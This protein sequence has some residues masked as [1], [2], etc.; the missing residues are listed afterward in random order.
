MVKDLK[1]HF[2]PHFVRYPQESL[3]GHQYLRQD[4]SNSITTAQSIKPKLRSAKNV[5]KNGYLRHHKPVLDHK[6]YRMRK[7][8]RNIQQI[9]ERLIVIKSPRAEPLLAAALPARRRKPYNYALA[10]FCSL[11]G[12]GGLVLCI[13]VQECVHSITLTTNNGEIR[14]FSPPEIISYPPPSPNNSTGALVFKNA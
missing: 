11:G 12:G 8:K 6:H 7:K 10:G 1:K 3:L 14:S 2:H 4:G 9:V 5:D 13:P